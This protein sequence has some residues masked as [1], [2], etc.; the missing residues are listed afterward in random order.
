V[1]VA[2]YDNDGAMDLFVVNQAG[3]PRLYRNVTP[4]DDRHWL[5]VDL[6][7]S[8]S[9]RDACGALVRAT[10]AGQTM[11]RSV[12]CGSGGTGS[13]HQ[14]QVH[15]GLGSAATVDEIEVVWPSGVRQVVT[16]VDADH[17]L[18]LEEHT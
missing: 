14:R 12:S 10:V 7:G 8:A 2:D 6:I 5:R 9:N 11:T 18:T 4:R 1:A 3:S 17:T 15:F 13:A 16:G